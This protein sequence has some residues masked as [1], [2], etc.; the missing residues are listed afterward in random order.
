V[1]VVA[2]ATHLRLRGVAGPA[3]ALATTLV[4]GSAY[5]ALARPADELVPVFPYTG[6]GPWEEGRT[7]WSAV[8]VGAVAWLVSTLRR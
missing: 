8:L 2:V 3:S 4:G 1:A 6:S 5:L 7:L